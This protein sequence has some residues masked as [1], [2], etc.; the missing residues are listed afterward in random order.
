LYVR[1]S[2]HGVTAQKRNIDSFYCTIPVVFC[3]ILFLSFNLGKMSAKS[4]DAVLEVAAI[5]WYVRRK[6][7]V[8]F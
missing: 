7:N 3:C 5:V 8:S 6:R 1:K 2:P 4:T